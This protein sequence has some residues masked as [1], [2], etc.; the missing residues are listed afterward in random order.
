MSAVPDP[1]TGL[2]IGET[3]D[4]TPAP[5]P[6]ADIALEGRH[7]RIVHLDPATHLD[8]L[9]EA[10]HG[11]GRDALWQY[12]GFAPFPDKAAFAAHLEKQAASGDPFFL[13]ILDRE[14]GEAVGHAAYMRIEPTHRVIEV[15]NVLFTPRLQ[16]SPAASEAIYLMARH[17]FEGMGYRRFEWKC[18][19]LNAP[20]RRAAHRYGFT[21]EGT[22]RQHMIIKGRSRDTAWYAMLD[23][24]WPARRRA[25]EIWLA[26]ENFD[27]EGRQRL[28]L[29]AL[30]A[31]AIPGFPM[32]RAGPADEA[33]YDAIHRAAYVW[34]REML[35]REP[36]PLLTPTREILSNYETWLL[37]KDGAVVGTAA[38]APNPDDLEIWSL[39]VDPSQQNAGIGR[40][41]LDAAEARAKALGLSTLK[42]FTG[43]PLQ[44]NIDWYHR[45]GYAT[46]REE[47]LPDGRILVHMSKTI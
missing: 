18:N 32:R 1:T 7:V 3:I 16:R 30:N 45:R 27:A 29:S 36:V 24:D 41:L 34:N 22:F 8:S 15:G 12:L 25:F 11:P 38:L 43:K 13:A 20:S 2:P 5:R 35:G 9:Y 6:A 42:L 19:D 14:S 33:A 23:G 40:T 44:K 37:E 46:D 31:T 28:A 47:E 21:Y 4:P 10:S 17:A 39:S 26:P